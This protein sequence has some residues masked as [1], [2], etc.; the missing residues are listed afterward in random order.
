[1]DVKTRHSR[2][3]T[4]AAANT[5]HAVFS[6]RAALIRVIFKLSAFPESDMSKHVP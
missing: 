6:K 5:D 3:S 2:K 1:M 4:G